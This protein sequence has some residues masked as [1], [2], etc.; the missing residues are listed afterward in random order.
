MKGQSP[1][2]I[3]AGPIG[4]KATTAA[5]RPGPAPTQYQRRHRSSPVSA[6][7][8]TAAPSPASTATPASSI[9]PTPTPPTVPGSA[10]PAM[11]GRASAARWHLSHRHRQDHHQQQ[12][13]RGGAL[14]QVGCRAAVRLGRQGHDLHGRRAAGHPH[15]RLRRRPRQRSVGFCQRRG[16]PA[17]RLRLVLRLER[18]ARERQDGRRHARGHGN[19]NIGPWKRIKYAGS[20]ISLDQAGQRSAP[21]SASPAS[22]AARSGV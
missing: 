13:R 21:P 5:G 22:T 1:I 20:R 17:E 12:R 19:D 11:A 2:A 18:V 6:A 14:Q 7:G 16:G 4:A 10:S 8:C 9:P 15:R 3:G